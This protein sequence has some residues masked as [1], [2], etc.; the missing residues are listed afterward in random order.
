MS[1]VCGFYLGKNLMTKGTMLGM[2]I[3]SLILSWIFRYITVA[4]DNVICAFPNKKIQ[5]F[6]MIAL[7]TIHIGLITI[8]LL[9]AYT[10]PLSPLYGVVMGILLILDSALVDYLLAKVSK[11]VDSL[12]KFLKKGGFYSIKI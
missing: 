2:M 6:M 8:S 1:C 7:Y 4:M 11:K 12:A 5:M 3:F 9:C 10:K